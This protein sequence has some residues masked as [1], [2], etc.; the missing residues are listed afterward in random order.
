MRIIDRYICL[1][2]LSAGLLSLAICTFVFFVPQLVQMMDLI[3]RHPG[4]TWEIAQLF[5]STFPGVL[6]F[7]LPIGVL[8][9]V[10][11]GLGRMS[12]DSELI[13]MNALGIGSSRLFIP[14]GA[15]AVAAFV[16]TLVMTLWLG[17]LSVRTLRTLEERLR[18]SQAPSQ[19]QPR[20][21]DERFP[22]FVLYVQD[23]SAAA[24]HWRGVFLAEFGA[25]DV[26]RLTLAD[27]AIVIAD[28]EQGKVDLHLHNGSSHDFS[29]S[30]PDHYGISAFRERDLSVALTDSASPRSLGPSNPERSIGSLLA[31]RGP[32]ARA[33]QVEVHRRLAFPAACLVF[34]LI[35]LPLGSRPRRGG[36]S[37]G[38]LTAMALVCVY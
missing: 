32:N 14:I 17:P 10:L 16:V 15:F 3:V 22:N 18:A 37:A 7:T 27:D 1:E 38:F 21:F 13:A 6:S 11:I 4:P 24:T 12:A 28:S 25:E 23:I 30:D 34:A 5:A 19:V 33:A 35:A 31:E 8:V 2:V 26:S 20:V 36:R 29:L 9:G